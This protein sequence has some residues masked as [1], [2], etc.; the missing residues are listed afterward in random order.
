MQPPKLSRIH[1]KYLP[2]QELCQVDLR[3]GDLQITSLIEIPRNAVARQNAI[4]IDTECGGHTSFH[5]A[6]VFEIPGREGIIALVEDRATIIPPDYLPQCALSRGIWMIEP[7]KT[8]GKD[9]A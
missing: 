4:F 9:V 6:Q 1:S 2:K 8:G 5:G 7:A 3:C